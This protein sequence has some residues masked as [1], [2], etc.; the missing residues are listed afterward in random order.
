MDSFCAEGVAAKANGGPRVLR[1]EGRLE[2]SSRE[3]NPR[4]AAE[5]WY[6]SVSKS[7]TERAARD[8]AGRA[9]TVLEAA[10]LDPTIVVRVLAPE[11]LEIAVCRNCGCTDITACDEGCYW[12]AEDLCSACVRDETG[13]NQRLREH[14]CPRPHEA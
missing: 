8:L 12:V 6:M 5:R 1:G 9:T 14:L 13:L 11:I 10:G 2:D 3:V 4:I 7:M